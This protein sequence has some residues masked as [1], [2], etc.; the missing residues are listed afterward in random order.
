[1]KEELY[2]GIKQK[3]SEV[4][5]RDA[6]DKKIFALIR[7]FDVETLDR[8]LDILVI[9]PPK[10]SVNSAKDNPYGYLYVVMKNNPVN[11]ER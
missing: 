9:R 3:F 11:H 4:F 5:N 8:A 6:D 2:S 7:L 1:M 10:N